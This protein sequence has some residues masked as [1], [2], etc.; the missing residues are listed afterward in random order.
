MGLRELREQIGLSQSD[1][2]KLVGTTV[3]T[4]S[5]WE[6][7]HDRPTMAH[8]RKLARLYRVDVEQLGLG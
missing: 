7:G 2:A 3:Q 5:R 1:V 8:R 6:N 4:V